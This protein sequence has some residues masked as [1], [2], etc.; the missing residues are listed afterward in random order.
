MGNTSEPAVSHEDCRVK[1]RMPLRHVRSYQALSLS[2]GR[3][4]R[5]G[6]RS[7]ARLL[8]P[9][10]LHLVCRFFFRLPPH[11]FPP[12]GSWA[13]FGPLAVVHR[14]GWSSST[15][16]GLGLVDVSAPGA[17]RLDVPWVLSVPPESQ[18]RAYYTSQGEGLA[19][20]LWA[21]AGGRGGSAKPEEARDVCSCAT[22]ALGE[23]RRIPRDTEVVVSLR[24][25]TGRSSRLGSGSCAAELAVVT[26][27]VRLRKSRVTTLEYTRQ[28]DAVKWYEHASALVSVT[29]CVDKIH[30]AVVDTCECLSRVEHITLDQDCSYKWLVSMGLGTVGTKLCAVFVIM[31]T[32]WNH[33]DTEE[34]RQEMPSGL[35][36]RHHC[37]VVF[38]VRAMA[39]IGSIDKEGNIATAESLLPKN[40]PTGESYAYAVSDSLELFICSSRELFICDILSTPVCSPQRKLTFERGSWTGL[41]CFPQSQRPTLVC[42]STRD[43]FFLQENPSG[44]TIEPEPYG[45]TCMAGMVRAVQPVFSS[46]P[47][48]TTS[49]EQRAGTSVLIAAGQKTYLWDCSPVSGGIVNHGTWEMLSCYGRENLIVLDL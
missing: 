6:P 36:I 35:D 11:A 32:E 9:S 13:S 44:W 34:K 31:Y 2:C 38:D 24:L 25:W 43:V 41:L 8:D 26:E 45:F 19:Q 42:Y 12:P 1:V 40:L 21:A 49:T 47:V 7:P 30:V 4:P 39:V 23:V 15:G 29:P 10:C 27:V 28:F 20:A 17:G 46:R 5:L 3:H 48:A 18:A 37:A 16:G 33:I 22:V 14:P